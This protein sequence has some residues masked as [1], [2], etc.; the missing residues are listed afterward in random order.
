MVRN[1]SNVIYVTK[2]LHRE[3]VYPFTS[4]HTLIRNR[5]N[6]GWR[7]K[8]PEQTQ[9][10]NQ[11]C[12]ILVYQAAKFPRAV[13]LKRVLFERESDLNRHL[14]QRSTTEKNAE[15]KTEKVE[16]EDQRCIVFSEPCQMLS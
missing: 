8:S 2:H 13:L 14:K 7:V 5:L 15:I 3:V 16:S 11:I 4:E 10:W 6:V 1:H 12:G 9:I